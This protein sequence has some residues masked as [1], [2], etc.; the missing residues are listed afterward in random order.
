MVVSLF[1]SAQALAQ[2][3][4]DGRE[5]KPGSRPDFAFG[6]PEGEAAMLALS[7]SSNMTLVLPQRIW[8][9]APYSRVEYDPYLSGWS[10]FT[11]ATGGAMIQLGIGYLL[12]AAYYFEIGSDTEPGVMALYN[13]MIESEALLMT[14][15][16][17]ML[18]KRA[19]GRC[20]PRSYPGTAKPCPEGDAFPSG[21][22]SAIGSFAGARLVRLAFTPVN[23]AFAL[24]AGSLAVSEAA[25]VVTG[26][27]RVLCGAHSIEDVIT[28]GLIGH[29]TGAG[30]ALIHWNEQLN[31]EE[32]APDG[33][34]RT[35]TAGQELT[36][37]EPISR[38]L[39]PLYF[40][41]GG[42]F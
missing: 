26:A 38:P 5:L 40:S 4:A 41:W 21:H 15:G 17:T 42:L 23:T 39:P 8:T 28:G 30:V 20:R 37:G 7:A 10:D 11:G 29:V 27:L 9:W 32:T 6:S 35:S 22:T 3:N 36:L 14:S 19:A 18:M 24:R 16:I 34:G 25:M 12:E 31:T 2:T 13:P 1:A 33:R